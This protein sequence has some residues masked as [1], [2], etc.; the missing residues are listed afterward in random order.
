[1]LSDVKSG[2]ISGLIFSKLA[3][4]ARNTKELLEFADLFRECNADLISLQ[5]SI[6]T[7]TPAGRLFYTMIAAMAQW[8]RE[9]IASRV[10][11]SVPVRAK[12][13]KS[14][15]GHAPFGYMWKDKQIML[16]P[17]EAPVRKL[18]FELYL[19]YQRKK[20]VA[21][22]LNEAGYRTRKGGLF[23]DTT[24]DRLLRD[25]IA[26][27]KHRRNYT[28]SL[29]QKKHWK[30]KPKTEWVWNDVPAVVSEELWQQVN[31]LLSKR[32][33]D[34]KPPGPLPLYL[35]TGIA[36]CHCGTRMYGHKKTPK[37]YCQT[38][39]NKI[40]ICDLEAL[41][42]EQLKSFIFSPSDIAAHLKDGTVV[43]QDKEE[44]LGT[45]EREQTRIE[46]EMNKVY[47]LYIEEQISAEGFGRTYGPLEER[48]NQLEQEIPRV[49]G[50]IDHL[51]IQHLSR[52]D[53]LSNAR[54][55]ASD[56]PNLTFKEK[57]R[58]IENLVRKVEIKEQ[59]VRFD[60]AFSPTSVS[61]VSADSGKKGQRNHAS[62]GF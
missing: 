29:G 24:I 37:Y 60:L 52:D 5:E 62:A 58:I 27:G 7:S 16:H 44:L 3:R 4:L 14:T 47:R 45:L 48:F 34:R 32:R 30:R 53:I 51:K 43:I 38:C 59:S 57:R 15:G 31:D 13:G 40:P 54:N 25:P 9:E 10:A 28:K 33:P 19:E 50:E 2:R 1:M 41:F 21:R 61:P 56:W 42:H 11:A 6:D 23:S 12:L 35:F 49:Q 18:M 36:T 39:R 8:E 22:V 55:L 20:R 46:R 17:E 26:K